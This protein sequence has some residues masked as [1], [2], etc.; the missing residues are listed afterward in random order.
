MVGQTIVLAL[1]TTY[2]IIVAGVYNAWLRTA[3]DVVPCAYVPGLL[4]HFTYR[5]WWPRTGGRRR[6]IVLFI[7]YL[8]AVASSADYCYGVVC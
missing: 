4:T 7:L 1:S 5:T 3:L 2:L 8:H 6:V